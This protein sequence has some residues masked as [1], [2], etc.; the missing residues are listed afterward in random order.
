MRAEADDAVAAT[1]VE[2]GKAVEDEFAVDFFQGYSDLK[3]RVA[4]D[5][6]E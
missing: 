6:L 4:A 1:R 5:H 2:A 3:R